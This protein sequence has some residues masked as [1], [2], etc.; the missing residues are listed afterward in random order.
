MF[1]FPFFYHVQRGLMGNV[2]D[3]DE[4]NGRDWSRPHV[5]GGT[6]ELRAWAPM[7][8]CGSGDGDGEWMDHGKKG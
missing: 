8:V 6:N 3:N 1:C 2:D 4:V 5:W 7:G